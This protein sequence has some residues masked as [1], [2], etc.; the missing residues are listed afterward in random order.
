MIH[1]VRNVP[2]KPKFL[3]FTKKKK[4]LKDLPEHI[5]HSK[6]L[7]LLFKIGSSFL[8]EK[9]VLCSSFFFLPFSHIPFSETAW[10]SPYNFLGKVFKKWSAIISFLGLR[11]GDWPMSYM[12][13]C[14][15]FT[16]SQFLALCFNHYTRLALL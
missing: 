14:L 16:V 5:R 8:P 12:I 6:D 15:E 4:V 9:F 3:I 10:A 1:L 7:E 2:Y 13:L 11:E